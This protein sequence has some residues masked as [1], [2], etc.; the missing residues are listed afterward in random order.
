MAKVIGFNITAEVLLT[1][2]NNTEKPVLH[3]HLFKDA[4]INKTVIN[5][6]SMDVYGLKFADPMV[7]KKWVQIRLDIAFF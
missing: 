5:I 6:F 4:G 1:N 7:D 3:A 2:D